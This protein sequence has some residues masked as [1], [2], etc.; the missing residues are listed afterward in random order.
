MLRSL[1]KN[2]VAK[3]EIDKKEFLGSFANFIDRGVTLFF[4]GKIPF[5][6]RVKQWLRGILQ[7]DCVQNVYAGPH[8]FYEVVLV[9]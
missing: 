9:S 2:E 7:A 5:L 4:T 8:G 6:W 3:V 1:F